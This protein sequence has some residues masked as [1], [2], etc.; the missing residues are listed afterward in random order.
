MRSL[1]LLGAA[2]LV[3]GSPAPQAIDFASVEAAPGPAVTG[4]P[5]LG[6]SSQMGVYD[7]ASASQ[8]AVDAASEVVTA[9][10]TAS[11]VAARG[12]QERNV[13]WGWWCNKG[14]DWDHSTSSDCTTTTSP[15]HMISSTSKV[16]TSYPTATSTSAASETTPMTTPATTSATGVVP[17]SCT[18]VSWTNT[19]A[20]TSDTACPTPYEVGT[21]CGFVNPEDPCAPQPGGN[22]PVPSPDTAAAFAAD[23]Q[24]HREARS[25]PTPAGYEATFRDL[26]ASVS[27]NTYLGY[28]LLDG[29]DTAGC[30]A[31]CDATALCTGFN[32]FAERD[33]AW[34]PD[35]CS[36]ALPP[37]RT[38]YKCSLWGAG[39]DAAAATNAGQRQGGAFE[40]VIAGSNGYSRKP[41]SAPG[42]GGWGPPQRCPGVHDHPRTGLGSKVFKGPFDASLCAGY[43]GAQNARNQR[44]GW[45]GKVAS[46]L[47]YS[48][49][50][51]NFFNAFVLK[52]DGVPVGTYCKLFAQQY[53][54]HQATWHGEVSAGVSWGFE[55]SFSFCAA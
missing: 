9:S 43:A 22:G 4:P 15:I 39:V 37:G 18:P 51:C 40:V 46:W 19:F 35:R 41:G 24:L 13:C 17:S 33:P 11:E 20:F 6:P 25:A 28:Q 48:N 45:F 10:A 34:N 32:V 27:G 3:A 54:P 2:A 14:Q 44:S 1:A 52:Q 7:R 49:G 26:N 8:Q 50:H 29:Y 12:L 55:S 21:Y 5:V 38:S 16:I 36:C 42:V 30:A 23:A 47:G 53:E 31:H